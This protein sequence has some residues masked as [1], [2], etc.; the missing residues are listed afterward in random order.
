VSALQAIAV[1]A[2]GVAAGTINAVIGSGTLITFPVLLAIGY[3][4]VTAN[5]T[6]TV[7]LVPGAA[8][9]AYAYRH[10]LAGQRGRIARFAPATALGA[11]AGAVLLLALP[12]GAFRIIVPILIA[13]ALVL[14]VLQ[15]RIA[16]AVE[17][18]RRADRPH[19]GPLVRAGVAATGVY[20]G[21]F[22]AG[23]GIVLFGMLGSVLPDDLRRVNALRN[24]LVGT[25]NGVSGVVFLFVADVKPLA[26][27]LVAA[28]AALG[29]VVGARIGRRLPPHV[30]RVVVVVVGIVAIVNVLS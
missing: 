12:A 11:V 6:N 1:L 25:A 18:R 26:A 23:Q 28:G 3:S 19:G 10:D 22:G 29:G 13:L 2:A 27:V 21:Y 9:A 15:P 17:H 14:V 5:V 4:P 16:A 30:L 7:G 20:G 8:S 24:L